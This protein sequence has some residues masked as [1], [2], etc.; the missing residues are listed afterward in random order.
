MA[1]CEPTGRAAF[2]GRQAVANIR[3]VPELDL[4]LADC[5]GPNLR[6]AGFRKSHHSFRLEGADG[7]QAVLQ[8]RGYPM[9]MLGSFLFD[10]WVTLE[11]VWDFTHYR[12]DKARTYPKRSNSSDA[13]FHWQQGQPPKSFGAWSYNT[14]AERDQTCHLMTDMLLSDI[15]PTVRT[16]LDRSSILEAA[17]RHQLVRGHPIS[18]TT[19]LAL[20]AD[21]GPSDELDSLLL[22]H[23]SRKVSAAFAHWAAARL[24]DGPTWKA[25]TATHPESADLD[26]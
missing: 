10:I 26:G 2:I 3:G 14:I 1:R 23:G 9:G 7:D 8:F 16:M 17:R 21:A 18:E 20:L 19:Y 12:P 5:V 11:P 13:T 25:I 22:G 6:A 24:L 4:F 15:L